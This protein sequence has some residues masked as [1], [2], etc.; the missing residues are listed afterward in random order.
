MF[1]LLITAMAAAAAVA[2]A[3]REGSV[4]DGSRLNDFATRYTAAWCS[5]DPAAV[6]SFYA[7]SGSLTING[8][9]PA[10]GRKAVE[11]AAAGFMKAYPDLV[12]KFDRLEARGARVLYHW[13]FV[14][15]NTGPGGTGKQVRISGYEDWNISPDGLIADSQGHYDAKDWDRQVRR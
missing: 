5:H 13:T 7:E 14:G 8:G 10:T 3:P 2:C 6:A 11:N 15:T 9:T 1:R 4:A 12:V